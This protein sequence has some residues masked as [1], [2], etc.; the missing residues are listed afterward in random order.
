MVV[1]VILS[2]CSIEDIFNHKTTQYIGVKEVKVTG[3]YNVEKARAAGLSDEEI[4]KHLA[5]T[6][7]YNL[8]WGLDNGYSY[9]EIINYLASQPR[10]GSEQ[11]NEARGVKTEWRLHKIVFRVNPDKQ[12]GVY[13]V[14]AYDGKERSPLS[15]IRNCI[16]ADSGNWE[17]E[18]DYNPWLWPARVEVVNGKFKFGGLELPK[19]GWWKWNFDKESF[20]SSEI[21]STTWFVWNNTLVWIVSGIGILLIIL[22]GWRSQI[23][24]KKRKRVEEEQTEEERGD[25]RMETEN[26]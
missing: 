16:V 3:T 10:V 25:S 12:D 8:Q 23:E 14:E 13:W 6:R 4:A 19:V 11:K 20:Q 21:V 22:N 18:M 24:E 2:G 5:A 15:R 1:I 26:G 7:N 9:R 17:G